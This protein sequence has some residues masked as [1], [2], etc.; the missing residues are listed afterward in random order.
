M[1]LIAFYIVVFLGTAE[2]QLRIT[3]LERNPVGRADALPG[4]R[5]NKYIACIHMGSDTIWTRDLRLSTNREDA[6]V[7]PLSCDPRLPNTSVCDR[8]FLLPG[9]QALILDPNYLSPENSL[10]YE[11][12]EGT[13]LLTTERRGVFT[14]LT[15][16]AG[17]ALIHRDT[18]VDVVADRPMIEY[19]TLER[20]TYES[21]YGGEND[22]EALVR[23][24]LF[25]PRKYRP[26][27][28]RL[29]QPDHYDGKIL[30]E[31]H[32]AKK[33][34]EEILLHMYMH[35]FKNRPIDLQ[36][37]S[38][39][40]RSTEITLAPQKHKEVSLSLTTTEAT[41]TVHGPGWVDTLDISSCWIPPKSVYISEVSPRQDPNWIEIHNRGSTPVRYDTWR[42][43]GRRDT[44]LFPPGILPAKAFL[45]ISKDELPLSLEHVE[46]GI[47]YNLGH[48]SDTLI[49]DMGEAGRDTISWSHENLPGWTRESVHRI[50]P[51]SGVVLG[52]PTP[53]GQVRPQEDTGFHVYPSVFTPK[54]ETA[55][56]LNISLEGASHHTGTG[57]I[58]RLDGTRVYSFSLRG[59]DRLEWDGRD[60]SGRSVPAGPLII[61]FKTEDAQWRREAVLWR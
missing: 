54:K 16:R 57:D 9:D 44:L 10:P 24:H 8:P 29:G 18:L 46:E 47:L 19:D 55:R 51:D 58:Y 23:I 36:Y 26:M 15:Q 45:L 25:G 11:I 14:D 22:H 50:H 32:Y 59:G 13:I 30:R 60:L 52:P 3:E 7:I 38:E 6:G 2:A 31:Y 4:G 43:Q 37:T 5:S 48:Y 34:E 20:F 56:R 35:N 42:L 40:G 33:N 17:C 41:R 61:I 39:R 1:F 53:G 27:E 12:P 28:R 49:L 21:P